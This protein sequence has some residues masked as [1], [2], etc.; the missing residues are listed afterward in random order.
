M[1]TRGRSSSIGSVWLKAYE[2]ATKED[3]MPML[4]EI[5]ERLDRVEGVKK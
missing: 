2:T 3:L 5:K 4:E 1:N